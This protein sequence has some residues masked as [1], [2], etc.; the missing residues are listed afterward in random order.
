[1]ATVRECNKAALVVVDVQV[2]VISEAW[3]ASRMIGNV[4]FAVRRA[5]A[6]SVPVIWVQHA[7]DE[8][9]KGSAQWQWVPEL[10][11]SEGEPRVH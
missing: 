10:V 6:E 2:G 1:M 3:N 7:D 9:P 8:L 11:P 5:W 4:A